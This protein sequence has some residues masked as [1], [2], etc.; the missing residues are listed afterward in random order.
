MGDSAG[1][2]LVRGLNSQNA[3]SIRARGISHLTL[4]LKGDKAKIFLRLANWRRASGYQITAGISKTKE[5]F[6]RKKKKN[7]KFARS[8]WFLLVGEMNMKNAL[9]KKLILVALA[10]AFSMGLVS[11]VQ[12]AVPPIPDRDSLVEVAGNAVAYVPRTAQYVKYHGKVRPIMK[13]AS[14][15]TEGEKDCKCPK[16]CDGWCFV[17]I[18]TDSL[19]ISNPIIILSVIWLRC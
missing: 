16:C 9:G 12:K 13:F 19:S 3:K 11:A 18:Y 10:C 1:E 7:E 4:G 17:I 15:L 5:V 8:F 14:T 6:L 2:G